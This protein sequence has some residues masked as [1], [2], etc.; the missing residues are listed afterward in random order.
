MLHR[1][2]SVFVAQQ[3][4]S[5]IDELHDVDRDTRSEL[6]A[7]RRELVKQLDAGTPWLARSAADALAMLDVTAAAAVAGLLEECP[8]VP[9]A[10]TAILEGRTRTVSATAFAFIATSSQIADIRMF[11]Q[12]LPDTLADRPR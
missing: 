5:T 8:V 9:A 6:R 2:V 11:M 7:L 10:L 12:M 4:L 1:D 3:L